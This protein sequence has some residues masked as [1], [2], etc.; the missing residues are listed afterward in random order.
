[1]KDDLLEARNTQRNKNK[2]LGPEVIK[3]FSCSTQLS[4]K[5]YLLMNSKLQISTVVFL[6]NLAEYVIFSAYE[7]ENANISWHFYIYQQRKFLAQLS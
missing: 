5:F 3:L 4:M 7:Y 2:R 6:L 1:M